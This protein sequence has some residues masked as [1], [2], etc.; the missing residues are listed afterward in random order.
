MNTQVIALIVFAVLAVVILLQLYNVLGRKAGFR[1]RVVQEAAR[2]QAVVVMVAAGAG[3]AIL[4]AAMAR[5]AGDAVA[6]LPLA[7]PGAAV[8]YVFAHRAGKPTGPLH[9]LVAALP[10]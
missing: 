4:P 2:G 6:A 10:K 8:T 1:P 3:L 7:T 9:D 5:L